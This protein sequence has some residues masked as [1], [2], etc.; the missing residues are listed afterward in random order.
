MNIKINDRVLIN[1]EEQENIMGYYNSLKD[2]LKENFKREIHYKIENMRI[3]KEIKDNE[4]YKLDNYSSFES[5]VK[6]YKVAKTQ[7]YAY[8]R[9]ASA[10]QDGI[11]QEDYIIENGIHN[12]LILIGNEEGKTIRKSRK[13]PI[14]PLRFQLKSQD[15][16]AFYK[17]NAKFTSFLMDKLFQDKK[18][19]LDEFLKEF[20][21]LKGN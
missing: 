10:L 11:I 15:S 13:N 19:L 14:K 8:L 2:K 21:S 4:Y 16:Y 20:K 3:L 12:S 9:L 7:A 6:E 18:D 1:K 17:K 5:F